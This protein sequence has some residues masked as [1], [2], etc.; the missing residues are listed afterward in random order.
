VAPARDVSSGTG[1]SSGFAACSL[2]NSH[3]LQNEAFSTSEDSLYLPPA[4]IVLGIFQHSLPFFGYAGHP[5]LT[6]TGQDMYSQQFMVRLRFAVSG[7]MFCNYN[8]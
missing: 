6:S 1:A 4:H 3:S 8:R 7:R 5:F 2:K